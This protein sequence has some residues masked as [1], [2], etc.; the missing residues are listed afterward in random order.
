MRAREKGHA[1][2]NE[3]DRST[4]TRRYK[5]HDI[6]AFMDHVYVRT[7]AILKKVTIDR[8][9]AWLLPDYGGISVLTFIMDDPLSCAK[10]IG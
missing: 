7:S 5:K 4:K 6:A 8:W 10:I 9:H 3:E 1:C 2:A